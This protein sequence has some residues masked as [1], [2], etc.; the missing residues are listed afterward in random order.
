MGLLS[1]TI[2]VYCVFYC[3]IQRDVVSATHINM[4]RQLQI[5][6]TALNANDIQ[7]IVET[8]TLLQELYLNNIK[9][10]TILTFSSPSLLSFQVSQCRTLTNMMIQCPA[11]H[12]LR[13]S[14]CARMKDAALV[15]L[16]QGIPAI[17][18]RNITLQI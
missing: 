18:V 8:C 9:D 5:V 1:L 13:L 2:S 14:W 15:A 16:L 10:S 6:R 3:E 11:L 4:T 7:T 17:Q 12:T